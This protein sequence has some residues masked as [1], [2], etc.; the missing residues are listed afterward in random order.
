MDREESKPLPS[1]AKAPACNAELERQCL[2]SELT[3][4][5]REMAQRR[6]RLARQVAEKEE[7][8]IEKEEKLAREAAERRD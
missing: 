8:R 2:E 1:A 4:I 3:K 5:K 7:A 6:G